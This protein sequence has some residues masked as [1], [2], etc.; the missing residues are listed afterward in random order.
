[1]Y[2]FIFILIYNFAFSTAIVHA[3]ES[4]DDLTDPTRPLTR[5]VS[6]INEHQTGSVYKVSQ[7]YVSKKSQMAIING[8]TVKMGDT[9]DGAE[10]LAIK[11]DRV[12]LLVDGRITELTI[13]PSFKQYKK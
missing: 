5:M 8:Q 1:M 10:V 2:K 3:Q 11:A 12:H 6:P 9:V 7:I 4:D 13:I